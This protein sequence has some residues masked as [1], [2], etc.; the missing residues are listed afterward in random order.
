MVC[1]TPRSLLHQ[2][3]RQLELEVEA[4]KR[5]WGR[6]VQTNGLMYTGML[7]DGDSKAYQAVVELQ[8]YRPDVEI[9]REQCVNHAYKRMGTALLKL[10]R[11]GA[12]SRGPWRTTRSHHPM[13]YTSSTLSHM[14]SPK[15]WCQSTATCLTPTLSSDLLRERHKTATSHCIPSSRAVARRRCFCHAGSFKALLLELSALSMLVH[16]I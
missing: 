13:K 8:P 7:G 11:E 10:S 5:L 3:P 6:S 14:M 16:H 4:A 12:S 1:C 9:V 15:L 2:L